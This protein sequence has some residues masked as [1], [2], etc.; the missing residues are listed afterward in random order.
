MTASSNGRKP[1]PP[2]FISAPIAALVEGIYRADTTIGLLRQKGNLGIGTFND[3]DGEMVLLD[4]Q[5]YCLRPQGDAELIPD[6][7]RT[8]FALTS[9]FK[10]DTED[11]FGKVAEADF[12]H[13]LLDLVPSTNLMYAIRIDGHFDYVRARSVPKMM[14]YMPLAEIARLQTVFEFTDVEG[15]II[16][17]YTPNFLAGV[18][19]PGLHLHFITK[20]R[21]RGGHLLAAAPG[22]VTVKLQHAPSVELGLP[23]TFDFLTMERVRDMQADLDKVER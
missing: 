15:T 8:P 21:T 12:E 7:V 13:A 5:V 9:Q 17:F 16:G 2:V 18:H 4:G 20:D 22:S 23:M 11:A 6:D 10:G 1:R 3:L 19:L 14:N